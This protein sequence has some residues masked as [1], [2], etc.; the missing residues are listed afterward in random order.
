[1]SLQYDSNES[2]IKFVNI[3]LSLNMEIFHLSDI[4]VI[5]IDPNANNYDIIFWLFFSLF[6]DP[7]LEARIQRLKALEANREY[8]RMTQ[9]VDVSVSKK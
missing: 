1:M 8:Q 7:E 9:N 6:Q 2:I 5:L 3:N 4:G